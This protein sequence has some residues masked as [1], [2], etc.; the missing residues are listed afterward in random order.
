VENDAVVYLILM[1]G[2]NTFS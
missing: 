2:Y 1:D